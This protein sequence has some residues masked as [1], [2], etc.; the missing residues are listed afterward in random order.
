MRNSLQHIIQDLKAL[1]LQD[2]FFFYGS[3][4]PYGNIEWFWHSGMS[5]MRQI[6]R[7]RL[8]VHGLQLFNRQL[9]TGNRKHLLFIRVNS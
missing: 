2:L 9:V 1:L 8:P 4:S 5:S 6:N 3:T 7:D